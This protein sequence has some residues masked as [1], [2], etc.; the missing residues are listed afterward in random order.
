MGLDVTGLGSIFDFASKVI[1]K[2]FPDKNA[3]LAAK[4]KMLELQTQNAFQEELNE[5]NITLEQLKTNAVEAASSSMWVS[6]WRPAFGW[7]GASAF[8]WTYVFG[9]MG[10]W[11]ATLLG[12]PVNVPVLDMSTMMPVVLTMLGFGTLRSVDKKTA[13]LDPNQPSPIAPKG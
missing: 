11:I 4:E 1:D 2:I 3:A 5:Y 12:H 13:T 7:V 6:G 8:A 9:P 10:S